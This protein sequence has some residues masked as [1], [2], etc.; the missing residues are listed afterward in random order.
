MRDLTAPPSARHLFDQALF[1]IERLLQVGYSK[2]LSDFSGMPPVPIIEDD[3]MQP[4]TGV[5]FEET[6]RY[7]DHQVQDDIV[8]SNLN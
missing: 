3:N 7:S 4:V 2:C 6:A 1:E 8:L 5:I